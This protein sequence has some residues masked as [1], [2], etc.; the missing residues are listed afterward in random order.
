[1][2]FHLVIDCNQ[3]FIISGQ[4]SLFTLK[5]LNCLDIDARGKSVMDMDKTWASHKSKIAENCEITKIV[6]HKTC[7][8]SQVS[9][10]SHNSRVLTIAWYE[11]LSFFAYSSLLCSYEL[12]TCSNFEI[13]FVFR[14]FEKRFLLFEIAP[15]S[16]ICLLNSVLHWMSHK[17]MCAIRLKE[18]TQWILKN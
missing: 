3:F 7:K 16:S 13:F 15:F 17:Q 12:K 5:N 11:T 6:H 1:M 4:L 10:Y 8:I 18:K 14:L 2:D 9:A